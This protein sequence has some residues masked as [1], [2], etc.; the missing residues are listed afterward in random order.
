MPKFRRSTPDAPG[1]MSS[2]VLDAAVNFM[3]VNGVAA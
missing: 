2:P 1:K 3:V